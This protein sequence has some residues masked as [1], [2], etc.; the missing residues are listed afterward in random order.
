M[1]STMTIK[2]AHLAQNMITIRVKGGSTVSEV[3]KKADITAEGDIF[4][5]GKRAGMRTKLR[6]GDIIGIVGQVDGGVR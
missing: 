5:N 1:A 3:L 2:V 4:V 6:N